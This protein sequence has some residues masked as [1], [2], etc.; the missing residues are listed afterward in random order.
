MKNLIRLRIIAI[1]I[2]A[3]VTASALVGFGSTIF[4]RNFTIDRA[5]KHC[6]TATKLFVKEYFDDTDLDILEI[7]EIYA[8]AR[9]VIRSV[10]EAFELKYM[11]MYSIDPETKVRTYYIVGAGNAEDDA[12][13]RESFPKGTQTTSRMSPA[14]LDVFLGNV[15]NGFEIV[16]NEYGHVCS[17]YFPYKDKTGKIIAVIGADYDFG[18]IYDQMFRE[19]ARMVIAVLCTLIIT[20]TILLLVLSRQVFVPIKKISVRMGNYTTEEGFK[21]SEIKSVGEIRDICSSFENMSDEIQKHIGDIQRMTVEKERIDTEL[22]MA[23]N[24]Q[25]SQ[26]L[27]EFPAF[28]ERTEFDI[29]AS[30]TPAKEVGGDFYDFFFIGDDHLALVIADVSGKGIPA[31]LFMMSSKMLINNY[32]L[33]DDKPSDILG[34][35]N[36]RICKGNKDNM[37]V[38]VWLGILELSTGKLTC[39]NAGHENPVIKKADGKFELLNDRHG[40]FIG[41]TDLARYK[42]YE[43]QLEKG[44]VLFVYTDGVPEATNASFELFG[45]DRMVGALNSAPDDSLKGLLDAVKKATDEFVGDAPQFDDLTMLAVKYFGKQ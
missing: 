15:D 35:V 37:F 18:E 25:A 36:K 24:I 41:A 19:V 5:G 3:I 7:P 34:A 10:C 22:N 17:W 30:M 13:L 9:F 23:A 27:T 39:C 1:F 14:E 44:D 20:L 43:I 33:F 21:A 8:E 4:Y 45:N 28:P 26:L 16:S 42:D 2:A 12:E 38:T 11:Y 29:Y 32:S 40:L 6:E 31:A